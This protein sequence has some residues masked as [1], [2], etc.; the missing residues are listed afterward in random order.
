[1]PLVTYTLLR[2]GVFVVALAALWFAGMGSWLLLVV[3][4]VVAAALSYVLFRKQR[5]AAVA[6]LAERRE[7]KE[8]ERQDDAAAEDAIADALEEAADPLGAAPEG[9]QERE[10]RS[11]SSQ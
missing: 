8:Q 2:L 4:A 1:M 10:R 6:W 7:R 9:T 3:A 11:E 5:D